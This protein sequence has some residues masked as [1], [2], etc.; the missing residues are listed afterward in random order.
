MFSVSKR[1]HQLR[2]L[3]LTIVKSRLW[4]IEAC[5]GI[6]ATMVVICHALLLNA[7]AVQ[8]GAT[9]FSIF[10]GLKVGR[11][12]VD[13][14]F[15]L[16]GFIIYLVHSGD[17]GNPA[18]YMN[19]VSRRL[20]RLVPTYWICT[21]L[22]F[23]LTLISPSVDGREQEISVII[24]SLFF[25]PQPDGP[26]LG[27]GWSL[28]HEFLFYAIF[29]TLIISKRL[30][31]VMLA[32]WAAIIGWRYLVG[33]V[34][35]PYMFDAFAFHLQFFLGMGVA[36]LIRANTRVLALP[37]MCLGIFGF[38]FGFYMEWADVFA[39]NSLYGKLTFGISGA[40]IIYGVAVFDLTDRWQIPNVFRTVGDATYSI[41]LTHTMVIIV[42]GEALQ[43]LN[44][45]G[46]LNE[47]FAVVALVLICLT[48]G[49]AFARFVEKPAI[50]WV[51]RLI[52][53]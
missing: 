37:C 41:Y 28:E 40:F 15:V 22:F 2:A 19:Y 12:G 20:T 11:V 9:D 48:F 42:I 30:G 36:A 44:L 23:V 18:R 29:S 10:S 26:V 4:G 14:F 45:Y 13:F 32:I 51:R 49:V 7:Q 1:F 8:S 16:S 47:F 39:T 46:L 27:I 50:N 21:A 31:L 52:T 43:R 3:Q 53:K 17:I 24:R 38:G 34:P 25:I 33:P 6:A 5:R 35:H